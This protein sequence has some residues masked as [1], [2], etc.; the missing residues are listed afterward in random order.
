MLSPGAL[1]PEEQMQTIGVDL[2]KNVF[3]L[4]ISDGCGK[5][6]FDENFAFNRAA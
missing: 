6:T 3:E 5:R 1:R 2:A 4:A